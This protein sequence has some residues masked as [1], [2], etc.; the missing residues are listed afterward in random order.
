MVCRLST[1]TLSAYAIRKFA[2]ARIEAVPLHHSL[3]TMRPKIGEKCMIQL[4]FSPSLIIIIANLV[5]RI[6]TYFLLVVVSNLLTLVLMLVP[7]GTRQQQ[8]IHPPLLFHILG[9]LPALLTYVASCYI[10]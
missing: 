7:W 5:L 4:L 3:G 8:E 10:R 6:E 9:T 2:D 1:C